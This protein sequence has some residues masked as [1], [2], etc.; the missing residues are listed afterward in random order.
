MVPTLLMY[1]ATLSRYVDKEIPQIPTLQ[2]MDIFVPHSER[3]AE[4]CLLKKRNPRCNSIIYKDARL[5]PK[6]PFKFFHRTNELE[7]SAE[8]Q[9]DGR[10]VEVL[11]LLTREALS[12]L[13]DGGNHSAMQNPPAAFAFGEIDKVWKKLARHFGNAKPTPSTAERNSATSLPSHLDPR[14]QRLGTDPLTAIMYKFSTAEEFVTQVNHHQTI[15][16]PSHSSKTRI[17]ASPPTPLSK[18]P[19]TSPPKTPLKN[20]LGAPQT[21][22]AQ[23]LSRPDRNPPSHPRVLQLL[24]QPRQQC[25]L[26]PHHL[27]SSALSDAVVAAEETTAAAAAAAGRIVRTAEAPEASA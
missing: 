8:P 4:F 21:S 24:Q 16:L 17:P 14:K 27:Q 18:T 7:A 23:T 13:T 25:P 19:T 6:H 12:L 11:S 9:S 20:G 26:Q 1:K 10:H 5:L 15:S 22:Q 3:Q 2:A